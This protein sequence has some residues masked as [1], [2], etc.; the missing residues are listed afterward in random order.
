MMLKNISRVNENSCL[1]RHLHGVFL[2]VD[3][4]IKLEGAYG[5]YFREGCEWVRA[6]KAAGTDISNPPADI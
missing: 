1:I 3:E 2:L 5:H 6:G 4:N